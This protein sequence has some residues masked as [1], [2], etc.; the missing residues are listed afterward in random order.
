MKADGF[1]EAIIG[2][3]PNGQRIVYSREKMIQVLMKDDGMTHEDAIEHLEYNV[4]NAHVG[5]HTPIYIE[6]VDLDVLNDHIAEYSEDAYDLD[7]M[8]DLFG[9][10]G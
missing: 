7:D 9:F 5:E 1:D 3:E 6:Q 8:D 2:L 10:M 4:W